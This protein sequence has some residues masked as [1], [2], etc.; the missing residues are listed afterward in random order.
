MRRTF[1]FLLLL[2]GCNRAAAP[3]SFTAEHRTAIVDSVTTMLTAWRTALSSKDA[4]RVAAFYA[5]DPQFRWIE[6]GTVRYTSPQ[7]LA[8]AYR[9]MMPSLR[10]L[11][12]T[13]DDPTISPLAPGTALVTTAFAQKVTD[14]LGTVTGFAGM[15]SMTVVHTDS[16][17]RFLAGHTSSVMPKAALPA[18]KSQ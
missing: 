2:L 10:T 18:L 17:W 12:V 13:L 6:D 4:G 11:D 14:T 9:T 5:N 15:L 1:P 3:A 7:Q 8:D 16:G